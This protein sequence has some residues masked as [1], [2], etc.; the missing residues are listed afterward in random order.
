MSGKTSG[1]EDTSCPQW[2]GMKQ[3]SANTPARRSRKIS[4]W[5]KCSCGDDLPPSRRPKSNWVALATPLKPLR[6]AHIKSPG[7]AGGT[8]LEVRFESCRTQSSVD[9][10]DCRMWTCNQQADANRPFMASLLFPVSGFSWRYHAMPSTPQDFT[11]LLAIF[12]MNCIMRKVNLV[13]ATA[14]CVFQHLLALGMA[15]SLLY[16]AT[17]RSRIGVRLNKRADSI[18]S[19]QSRSSR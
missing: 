7:S 16:G 2:A 11:H 19:E 6:A 14:G 18:A 9:Y 4:Y 8:L 5:I 12:H 15:P 17:G 10:R 13:G 1:H 3:R